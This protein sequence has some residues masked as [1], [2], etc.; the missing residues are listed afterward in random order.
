MLIVTVNQ[1]SSTNESGGVNS[2]GLGHSGES[3]ADW[4]VVVHR[5]ETLDTTLDSRLSATLPQEVHGMERDGLVLIIAQRD[6][7]AVL[8]HD[9]IVNV[10]A[11]RE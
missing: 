6:G 2:T 10:E 9:E 4:R 7:R 5:V 3:L 8:A 11:A 1:L